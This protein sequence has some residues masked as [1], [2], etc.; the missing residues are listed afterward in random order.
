[1]Y[2]KRFGLTHRPFPVTPDSGCY[3]PATC[4]EHALHQLLQAVHD[5]E[6]FALV[7]GMPGTGKTVLCHC[8]LE[9]LGSVITSA[10]LTNSHLDDRTALLQAIL[11]DLSLPYEGSEQELRLR[12]MEFL[13]ENYAA[14]KRAVLVVDEAQ[15]LMPDVLEE[16]RL[17][18]NLESGQGKAFQVVLVGQPGVLDTLS[19]PGLAAVSQ[20]VAV[21]TALEP[22]DMEETVDYTL[23]HLR[24][25]GGRAESIITA[26]ALE[27]LARGSHGIPRLVNRSMH[28]ALLL[29]H[30]AGTDLVDVEVVLEALSLLGLEVEEAAAE[31]MLTIAGARAEMSDEIAAAALPVIPLPAAVVHVG[32]REDEDNGTFLE[33]PGQPA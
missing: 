24:A 32:A 14:G 7:T 31:R 26:D 21:R 3:Y 12:C 1:M 13:L 22:L 30:A 9:R 27:M 29:A 10:Y 18:G 2:E 8:L 33:S 17:L 16:M 15:N 6:G 11:Y 4:H 5:D 23:H 19:Q 28:Q 25:A 20:R